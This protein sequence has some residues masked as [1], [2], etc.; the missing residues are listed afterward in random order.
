MLW[1][2]VIGAT[3]AVGRELLILPAKPGTPDAHI[4]PVASPRPTGIDIGKQLG[5]ELDIEPVRVT[6]RRSDQAVP[7]AGAGNEQYR[8]HS[9]APA[10]A[11]MGALH[12]G[13]PGVG[14]RPRLFGM[15]VYP[16][17]HA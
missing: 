11:N 17:E 3:G 12:A 10:A 7:S 6:A 16:A 14:G 8:S 13:L 5:L 4:V 15:A 9:L 2:A 1:M